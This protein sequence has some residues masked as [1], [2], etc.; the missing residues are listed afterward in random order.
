MPELGSTAEMTAMLAQTSVGKMLQAI[1]FGC[2]KRKLGNNFDDTTTTAGG[3]GTRNSGAHAVNQ[4]F[5]FLARKHHRKDQHT[6]L[7]LKDPTVSISG[8]W[9][10]YRLSLLKST[11]A[12]RQL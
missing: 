12:G 8:L 1:Q 9:A 11:V 2:S 6:K 4:G 3:P 7:F 5:F 10:P